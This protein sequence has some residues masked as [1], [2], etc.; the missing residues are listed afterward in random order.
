MQQLAAL[1]QIPSGS[2]CPHESLIKIGL[3][4]NTRQSSSATK[5][6]HYHY[7]YSWDASQNLH[8][9]SQ[10]RLYIHN[11]IQNYFQQKRQI[12]IIT[13]S[14]PNISK[15]NHIT[16]TGQKVE[17]H[18]IVQSMK[19]PSQQ[20]FLVVIHAALKK[21]VQRML[22]NSAKRNNYFK[23]YVQSCDKKYQKQNDS[24]ID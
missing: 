8:V 11:R 16:T 7:T 4:S 2:D 23:G 12:N 13:L 19:A 3:N 22:Y 15:L 21:L 18:I 14:D 20:Q 5:G 24:L 1:L 17:Q 6:S 9:G 10:Y